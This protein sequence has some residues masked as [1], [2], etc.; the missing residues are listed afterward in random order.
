MIGGTYVEFPIFL[1]IID[2]YQV[3]STQELFYILNLMVAMKTTHHPP[4]EDNE[5]GLGEVECLA[6]VLHA[7]MHVQ[8]CCGH[9]TQSVVRL[10]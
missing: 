10:L 6:Q 4:F 3:Y 2:C 5:T 9:E 7:A 1:F 8:G